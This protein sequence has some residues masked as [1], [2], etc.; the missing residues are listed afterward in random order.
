MRAEALASECGVPPD[1]LCTLQAQAW[2]QC[3]G[4]SKVRALLLPKRSTCLL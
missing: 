2:Y 1:G 3:S 4:R